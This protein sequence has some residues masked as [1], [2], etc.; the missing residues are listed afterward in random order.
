VLFK[1]NIAKTPKHSR[2]L[3]VHGHVT[4]GGRRILWPSYLVPSE[5]EDKIEVSGK[6]VNA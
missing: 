6:E 2:Q 3:I 4:I 1:K 5:E